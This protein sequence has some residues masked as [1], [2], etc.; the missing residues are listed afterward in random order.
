MTTKLWTHATG[1]YAVDLANP[2]Q[3]PRV[4]DGAAP[5]LLLVTWHDDDDRIVGVAHGRLERDDELYIGYMAFKPPMNPT[6][7]LEARRLGLSLFPGVKR[8]HGVRLTG[9]TRRMT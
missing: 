8:F 2:F 5:E 9:K 6:R 3:E 4:C 7:L 1:H